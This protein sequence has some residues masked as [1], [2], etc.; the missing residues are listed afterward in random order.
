MLK[1]GDVFYLPDWFG[2]HLNFV[3]KVLPDNSLIICN[4][5]DLNRSK[6][7]TCVVT[8][9]ELECLTKDSA[10]YFQGTYHCETDMQI[11][12]LERQIGSYRKPL[13]VKLLARLQ[14]GALDSP[15]T[16]EFIKDLLK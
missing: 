15:H 16:S 11:E 4:F 2:G 1:A 9:N 8:V 10:A 13:S 12:A 7:K 5:T 3:L 6:D 14:Q